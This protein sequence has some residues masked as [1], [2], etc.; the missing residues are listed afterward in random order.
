MADKVRGLPGRLDA[1]LGGGGSG[2]LSGGE[3]RRLAL[4]RALLSDAPILILDEPAA[5]L[6]ATT[7]TEFFRALNNAAPGRTVLLIVHRLIG[8][9]RLDR[10]W[11]LTAGHAVSAAR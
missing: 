8:V 6:D 3:G 4:A 1:V 10:I 7:E 2:G 9:E 11:R 5:G